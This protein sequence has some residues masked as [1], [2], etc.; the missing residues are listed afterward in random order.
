LFCYE[1]NLCKVTYSGSHI[2]SRGG[3]GTKISFYF[4][5]RAFYLHCRI[6]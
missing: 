1:G 3:V 6:P 2:A 5:Q 4:S